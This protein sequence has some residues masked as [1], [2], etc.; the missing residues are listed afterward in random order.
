[1]SIV[2]GHI[3]NKKI[4]MVSKIIEMHIFS[5]YKGHIYAENIDLF[6]SYIYNTNISIF[7]KIIRIIYFKNSLLL[8]LY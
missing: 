1:M 5:L 7:L 2:L 6:L 4:N 8:K 3:Y